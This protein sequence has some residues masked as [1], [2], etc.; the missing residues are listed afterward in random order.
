MENKIFDRQTVELLLSPE[1]WQFITARTRNSILE[2][3]KESQR[4]K[5]LDSHPMREILMT[6]SGK[7][8]YAYND[9]YYDCAPGVIFLIDSH[10]SHENYYT[11]DAVGLFH[12][13]IYSGL[14]KTIIRCT[15]INRGKFEIFA[16]T[17]TSVTSE[18]NLN[19]L[20]DEYNLAQSSFAQ[21]CSLQKLRMALGIVFCRLLE[22]PTNSNHRDYLQSIVEL[23]KERIQKDFRS[24]TNID[25]LARSA[26]YSR[27][28]F[29]R[30]FKQYA[31]CTV[32][33]YIDSCRI[34]EMERLQQLNYSQKE[35]ASELGFA[36][37]SAF[38]VW[39]R[40]VSKVNR[41]IQ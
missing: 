13:W 8:S 20:W 10:M 3:E 41:E 2:Q 6:V 39:R 34:D 26:G 29:V 11:S 24:G 30:V 40:K 28:H 25:Y 19:R 31:N 5:Q 14:K 27:Y 1:K 15:R 17:V 16:W 18:I 4:E 22:N 32:Q 36:G 21:F 37:P 33:Q 7:Y 23:T 9:K 38:S 35:I 12:I